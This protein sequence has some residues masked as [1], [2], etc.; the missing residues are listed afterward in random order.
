MNKL[1]GKSVGMACLVQS[2]YVCVTGCYFEV[3]RAHSI[4][5]STITSTFWTCP[6]SHL[7]HGILQPSGSTSV[8]IGCIALVMVSTIN[9]ALYGVHLYITTYKQIVNSFWFVLKT[10][11]IPSYTTL[12][13]KLVSYNIFF[14]LK[15]L[16][17]DLQCIF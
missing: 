2:W 3:E 8:T 15:R 17:L 13:F 7:L 11:Y 6:G 10:I 9:I 14:S 5:T 4:S 16:T 12:N 1:S